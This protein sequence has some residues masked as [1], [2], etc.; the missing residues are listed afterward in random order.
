MR[1]RIED[2]ELL[3]GYFLERLNTVSGTRKYFSPEFINGLM[4][5]N[6]KGNVRELQNIVERAFHL[7]EGDLINDTAAKRQADIYYSD[8]TITNDMTIRNHE[9]TAIEKVLEHTGGQVMEAS[10]ILGVS[11]SALYRKIKEYS[12]EPRKY[13]S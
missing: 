3:A 4:A 6:W 5:H 2:I 7:T 11:K 8:F 1:N 9:K 10:S 13:C 12:I